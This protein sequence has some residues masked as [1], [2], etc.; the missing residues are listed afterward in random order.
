M[1]TVTDKAKYKEK[2]LPRLFVTDFD[3]VFQSENNNGSCGHTLN[4]G[5]SFIWAFCGFRGAG[6]SLNMTYWAARALID[7]RR[8]LSNMQVGP[9]KAVYPDGKV[10]TLG[11]EPLDWNA[12]LK[13]EEGI[14]DCVVCIDELQNYLSAR[15]S[16]TIRNRIMMAMLQQ[17]RHR[18]LDLMYTVK[19]VQWL[20]PQARNV[21][22]DILAMCE[23]VSKKNTSTPKGAYFDVDMYDISGFWTSKPAWPGQGDPKLSYNLHGKKFWD[24]YQSYER[25]DYFEQ[26]APVKM[27]FAPIVIGD[28]DNGKKNQLSNLYLCA[29]YFVKQGKTEMPADEFIVL[30]RQTF[31]IEGDPTALG[32]QLHKIGITRKR[33]RAGSYYNLE[34]LDENFNHGT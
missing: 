21:E 25:V 3:I 5:D 34:N 9:F 19:T 13:L 7:G 10:R 33:T 15:T 30:A 23:D 26:Q 22:T 29:D 17:L 32:R 8:V 28:Y 1:V 24:I 18:R 31:G 11:S 16:M 14:E 6:K 20:D 2:K 27:Q 12:M 4:W